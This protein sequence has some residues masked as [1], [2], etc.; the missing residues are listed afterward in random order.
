VTSQIVAGSER[1]KGEARFGSQKTV[2]NLADR[3]VASGGG[4][5]L[6]PFVRQPSCKLG[7]LA[8]SPSFRDAP[9]RS[10]R[11]EQGFQAVSRPLAPSAA[12][13]GVEDDADSGKRLVQGQESPAS[14]PSP[15]HPSCGNNPA[16]QLPAKAKTDK[17]TA[18]G[19]R[20]TGGYPMGC[21]VRDSVPAYIAEE[22]RNETHDSPE[23]HGGDHRAEQARHRHRDDAPQP[24]DHASSPVHSRDP[25]FLLGALK[26]ST[27]AQRTARRVAAPKIAV[28]KR[29]SWL[30]PNKVS[31][32]IFVSFPK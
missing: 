3:S 14:P 10:G 11:R 6:E 30:G 15:N 24:E 27:R 7:S 8:S 4:N 26:A 19:A 20:Q 1:Q 13:G 9:L 32:P 29:R 16:C 25:P 22:I 21:V 23:G 18:H 17:K 2:E 5:D 31:I 12:R 28:A